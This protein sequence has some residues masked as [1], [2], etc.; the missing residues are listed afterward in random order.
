M[1][2]LDVVVRVG[3]TPGHTDA[4]RHWS[5]K[6]MKNVKQHGEGMTKYD[7]FMNEDESECV[8]LECYE[9]SEA[10]LKHMH[11]MGNLL[12]EGSD[13]YESFS[14]EMFGNPSQEVIDSLAEAQV[15]YYRTIQ[16]L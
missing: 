16:V 1:S 5:E 14:G 9:N 8:V 3:I 11:D 12:M 7:W 2:K 15:D 4:F 6:C 10:L 13:H